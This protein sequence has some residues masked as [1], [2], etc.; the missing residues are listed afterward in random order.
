MD[1][2][3]IYLAHSFT[4]SGLRSNIASTERLSLAI[5][6]KYD[7]PYFLYSFIPLVAFVIASASPLC[8]LPEGI[9]LREKDCKFEQEGAENAR[10]CGR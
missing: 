2:P 8:K 10:V 5:Q 6:L 1:F 9:G 3:S 7:T 4:S